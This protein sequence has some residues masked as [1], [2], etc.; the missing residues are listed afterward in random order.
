MYVGGVGGTGKSRILKALRCA[1]ELLGRLDIIKYMAPT[2]MAAD[3]IG[4]STWVNLAECFYVAH[5]WLLRC[6]ET[7][8]RLGMR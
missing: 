4:G 2:G 8:H 3:V 1:F 7:T 6:Q 5:A